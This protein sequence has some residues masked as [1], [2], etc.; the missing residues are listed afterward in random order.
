MARIYK[1]E[2]GKKLYPVCG[3]LKHQH[4]ILNAYDRAIIARDEENTDKAYEWVETVEK[5]LEAYNRHIYD[6]LVYATYDEGCLIKDL[7]AAYDLRG[8]MQGHWKNS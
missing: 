6:G 8:D 3:F 4:K 1:N 7:I 2:E 5:A